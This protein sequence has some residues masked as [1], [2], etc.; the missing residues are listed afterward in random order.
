MF[1][2]DTVSH[3]HGGRR[4]ETSGYT[5]QFGWAL[6]QCCEVCYQLS[7]HGIVKEWRALVAMDLEWDAGS[8]KSCME[9]WS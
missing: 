9:L 4:S 6:V 5:G 8:W 1:A 2:T 7:L 3:S